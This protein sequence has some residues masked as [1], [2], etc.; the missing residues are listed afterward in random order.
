MILKLGMWGILPLCPSKSLSG[1]YI[2]VSSIKSTSGE[3]FSIILCYKVCLQKV[4]SLNRHDIAAIS[5]RQALN[6]LLCWFESLF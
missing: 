5:K 3:V 2:F 1:H 4:E 6:S